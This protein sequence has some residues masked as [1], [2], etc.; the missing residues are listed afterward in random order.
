MAAW[1]APALG[2]AVLAASLGVRPGV[3]AGSGVGGPATVNGPDPCSSAQTT[4]SAP[5]VAAPIHT[6]RFI[7]RLRSPA[8]TATGT[9]K[10]ESVGLRAL[11]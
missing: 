5:A 10:S 1:S 8:V 7:T 6:L 9:A 4:T 3:A 11:C 2:R